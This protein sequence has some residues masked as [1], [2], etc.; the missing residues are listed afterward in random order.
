[1]GLVTGESNETN[2]GTLLRLLPPLNT[3]PNVTDT[4]PNTAYS[5]TEG[6]ERAL[7]NYARPNSYW[8]YYIL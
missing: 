5:A 2:T 4:V 8:F 7:N 6:K 1:M 3:E